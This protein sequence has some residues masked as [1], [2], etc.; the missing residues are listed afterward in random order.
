[1][2]HRSG[3]NLVSDAGIGT[4]QLVQEVWGR[5]QTVRLTQMWFEQ[6]F[7]DDLLNW[8][9]GRVSMGGDF[10]TFPCDF[11]NLT[12]CGSQ[13]GNIA[14]GYIFNWPI[15]Q[16]GS[17]VKVNLEGIRPLPDRRLRP[18][19]AV[20]GLRE[21]ALAGVVPGLDGRAGAGGDRLEPEVRRRP[22]RA[23]TRSAP[24]TTPRGGPDLFLDAT[25]QP[26]A[27]PPAASP[28]IATGATARTS[29]SS[30]SSVATPA[31]AA[32]RCSSMRHRRIANG[33][34][35]SAGL[36]RRAVHRPVRP[37]A[38]HDWSRD[39]RHP[40]QRPRRRAPAALQPPAPGRHGSVL[41][42]NE[43]VAELIYAW[44]PV[45]AVTLRPNLQYVVH[46]GGSSRN[47]DA[48]VVG[49][50]SNTSPSSL[51]RLHAPQTCSGPRSQDHCR[52]E[53]P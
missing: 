33:R 43:Y 44:R 51:A 35:R 7:F 21:Q 37:R 27:R 6:T 16:W 42:G 29:T 3:D 13:P 24:G 17:R 36:A 23:A 31:R 8:K 53:P 28:C 47:S 39:R 9:F 14:G 38:R 34:H 49:L 12:F 40:R 5:G 1:M 48:F 50:K 2:T 19:P 25:R 22:A 4:F 26:L 52:R 46:P 11:Q 10:A 18:E 32:R 45:P 30:S 15:S 41:D 20:S